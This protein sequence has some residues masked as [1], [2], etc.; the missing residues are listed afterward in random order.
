M[1]PYGRF[2]RHRRE[3]VTFYTIIT[4]L[5]ADMIYEVRVEKGLVNKIPTPRIPPWIYGGGA[6][7]EEG[8]L[9]GKIMRKFISKSSV[10]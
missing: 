2:S 5:N 9:V 4:K 3:A 6:V 10:P 8:T 7:F 1:Y